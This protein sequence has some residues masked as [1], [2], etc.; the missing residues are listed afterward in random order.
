MRQIAP[1]P[2]QQRSRNI[3]AQ[4]RG[5]R[6]RLKRLKQFFRMRDS[7]ACIFDVN[8]HAAFVSLDLDGE[9]FLPGRFH[10]AGAIFRKIEKHLQ[11]R[12]PLG[13][14]LR[15][16][17]RSRPFDLHARFTQRRFDHDVQLF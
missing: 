15:Q 14:D 1:E 4:A 16:R 17:F 2:A 3:Q 8:Q 6:A 9:L 12:V 13:P 11:Q 10:R 7:R 5:F